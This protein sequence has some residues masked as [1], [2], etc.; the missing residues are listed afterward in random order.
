MSAAWSLQQAI[1]AAL[2]K[3]DAVAVLV[4]ERVFDHVPRRT[5][6]PYVVVG[7][8]RESDWSTKTEAGSEH[9]LAIHVWSR[10]KGTREARLVTQAVIDALDNAALKIAGFALIDLCWR[11][12]TTT[13][14]PDGETLHAQLQFRAVLE[15]EN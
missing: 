14:E 7:E 6:F 9:A 12:T 4:G 13:R 5:A 1:F 11:D 15:K 2:T 10:A 3:D 8:G